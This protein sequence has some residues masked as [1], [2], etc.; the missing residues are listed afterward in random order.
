[1]K[2]KKA[3]L[4]LLLLKVTV[5]YVRKNGW[6]GDKFGHISLDLENQVVLPK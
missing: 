4:V 1:M 6:V 2:F 5:F 3:V